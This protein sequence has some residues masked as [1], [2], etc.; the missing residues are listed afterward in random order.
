[1]GFS[2]M[3]SWASGP[4]M[5]QAPEL[6]EGEIYDYEDDKRT[7]PD[8]ALSDIG[9]RIQ[10][11][12]GHFQKDFQGGV[13]AENLGPKFGGCSSFLPMHKR[14]H[15]DAET[16]IGKAKLPRMP[17]FG[18][19]GSFLPMYKRSLTDA[20]AFTAKAELPP[21]IGMSFSGMG[22]RA[23]GPGMIHAPKLEGVVFYDKDDKRTN[24][25]I[26]LSYIGD[27]VQ[28]LLGH[29]QK[30]FEG[31]V[32]AENLGPKF[33]GYG[34]FLP[35]Y[36]RSPTDTEVFTAKAELPP[37]KSDNP[38]EQRTPKVSKYW[39]IRGIKDIGK[40]SSDMGSRASGT[41]MIQAPELEE[42]EFCYDKDDKRTNP[43]IALSYI[44]DRVQSLLGHFQKDFEG[45]VSAENLGPKFGG[46]GSF[47]PMY[48]RSPTDAEAFTAKAEL[49]PRKSDNPTEQRTPK[50]SKY[51]EI[52]GIKDIGKSSS[53]MGSRASGPGMIQAP[54]LEEGEFCYDKDDKR[55][56]PDIALSDIG[57]G[58][59]SSL[60]HILPMHKRS[61]TDAEA[62]TG[63]AEL[64]PSK[65]DNPTERRT[66]NIVLKLCSEMVES[67]RLKLE[68]CETPCESPAKILQMMTHDDRHKPKGPKNQPRHRRCCS[69][70][71]KHTSY[72]GSLQLQ[73]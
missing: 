31:G 12:Q 9:D 65:S 27:R 64:P 32:S 30:D 67:A 63:K 14:S 29:F 73:N 61:R 45:V 51:W 43:D 37:S 34:S 2:D 38:T 69:R 35:M 59:Q 28:S 56:N 54:E 49:P 50:V 19:Y 39:E 23:S 1:M 18:G 4:G 33:G 24:P 3:V 68:H 41:G 70:Q 58:F 25:E 17:K 6:E 40:S 7:N 8:I 52:R 16:F 13:S 22:S 26:A 62:F 55:T 72:M 66:L 47:L 20:E 42:G 44:G 71:S 36:K 15:T 60:G 10:S 53:D 46:Y 11:L 5:I 21:N 48:K 57:D